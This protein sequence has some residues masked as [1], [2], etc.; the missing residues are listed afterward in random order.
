MCQNHIESKNE[1]DFC[2]GEELK[3]ILPEW[4]YLHLSKNY[5]LENIQE[6]RIRKNQVIQI[7]YKGK[8]VELKSD[9]GLYLKSIQA[10]QELIDYIISVAT[11]NSL[12][13]YDEQIK[14]GFIVTEN[15]IRIGICGTAVVLENKIKFIKNISSLN[16]RIGHLI[17][18]CANE[19]MPYVVSGNHVKNT[20]ILS[21][22]GEGKTTLLRDIVLKLSND[23]NI[24]N[25]MVV[26]EKFELGGE[27]QNFNLGK[28]VDMMQG[29]N[30]RFSFYDSV[31][32]MNP[33]VI[34]TDELVTEEDVEGVKFAVKSGV[35][36]I[37]T[38]HAKNLDE[39]KTKQY[40]K[41]LVAEKYFERF[42]VLSKRN[43]VG[44]IEGVFDECSFA[45]YL[46]YL[47]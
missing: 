44:T 13:A 19:I 37:A 8:M 10:R 35:S 23:Y 7:S 9:S 2:R 29:A 39:L 15:G 4:L 46:P 24:P 18:D 12:Y 34:A 25:I 11:K 3:N 27:K 42:I 21:A 22:P 5:S 16:I 32:V 31:K 30:K 45:L 40:F 28:N 20:L 33:S 1:I 38:V 43:G 26:D 41:T 47:K 17:Q 36:V 6:I 14:N